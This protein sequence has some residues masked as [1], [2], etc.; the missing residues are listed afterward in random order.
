MHAVQIV[1]LMMVST[2]A[3]AVGVIDTH[4]HL[5]AGG[6]GSVRAD[7]FKDFTASARKAIEIMDQQG[8]QTTLIMPTPQRHDNWNRYDYAEFL[9]ALRPYH[10]RFAFLGG[11]ALLNSLIL[12]SA[13]T[14][15]VSDEDRKLFTDN[16]EMILRDG[17]VGFG[18]MAA[19]HFGLGKFGAFHSYQSAPPDHELFLLLADIAASHDVPID[20]HMELI[21]ED[22]PLPDRP[23]LRKPP[24]PD[25]LRANLAA[26]ERLLSHNRGAKIIWVHA[27]WDVTGTRDIPT[28][29]RLLKRHPNLYMSLKLTA[30][31]G[32]PK[33]RPV[34]GDGRIKEAWVDLFKD[35]PDRFMVGTDAFYDGG[36]DWG[37]ALT[38]AAGLVEMP[39]QLLRQ[40]PEDLASKIGHENARRLYKLGRT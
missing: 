26:F 3:R 16:A 19:E 40:L 22:M 39:M 12:K 30:R 25:K 9:A 23:G 34:D 5:V 8:I 4:A 17:A 14:G 29:R 20:L 28:M 21:P 11:G 31:V 2:L 7:Y 27:G 1:F 24:N 15:Q 18:E 37:P 36:N 6:P 32:V 33:S 38:P 13:E 35:F 10:D